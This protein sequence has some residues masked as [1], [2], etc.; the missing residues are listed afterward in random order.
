[1]SKEISKIKAAPKIEAEP[2]GGQSRQ[3]VF[4]DAK[5]VDLAHRYAVK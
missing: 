4:H 2:D 3:T 5:R 1:M